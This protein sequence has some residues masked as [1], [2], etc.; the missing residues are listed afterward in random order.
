MSLDTASTEYAGLTVG[1]SRNGRGVFA[2]KNFSA[3]DV[4]YEV[5]GTLMTCD[6]DD[7]LDDETRANT[8][9]YDEA[10][11]LSPKGTLG[12]FFNH[13]CEPNAKIV[14]R[15]KA[16]FVVARAPISVGDEIMFDYSTLIA[17][18]DVW[19]MSCNCGSE[20]CR[21][22]VSDVTSLPQ[23]TKQQ[24]VLNGMIPEYIF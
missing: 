5:V 21:T 11:F 4:L 14:K 18:D 1:K 22:I 17:S 23:K 15:D 19:E 8:Y 16:L 6:V 3:D 2:A 20:Q 10:M 13:S 9:R 12:D 24:Y 7:D